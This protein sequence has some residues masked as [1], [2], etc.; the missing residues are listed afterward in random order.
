MFELGKH[1]DCVQPDCG[2]YQGEGFEGDCSTQNKPS[3]IAGRR[4]P[5]DE[6][7]ARQNADKSRR[8]LI[9]IVPRVNTLWPYKITA[10]QW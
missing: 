10:K 1:P 7:L 3:D 2:K 5:S 9:S 6:P 4:G 8:W